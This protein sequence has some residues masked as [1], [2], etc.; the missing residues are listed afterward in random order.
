[1]CHWQWV[2]DPLGIMDAEKYPVGEIWGSPFYINNQIPGL[3]VPAVHIYHMVVFRKEL[4]GVCLVIPVKRP[5][6]MTAVRVVH[7]C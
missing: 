5:I 7:N 2:T 4:R 6:A 1:M 3:M